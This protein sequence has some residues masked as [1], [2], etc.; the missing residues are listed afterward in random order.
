M[1][2][3]KGYCTNCNSHDE[4]R[5][6]F[7]VNSEAKFCYC[8]H[9]GKKYRPRIA[10]FN[11][12]RT[13][14]KYLRK[15]YFF[16]KNV[17]ETLLAYN[18]FA[19]V[20]ELEPTNRTAKYGRLLS[21]AYLS[22]LRRNRFKETKE[23]L[24]IEKDDFHIK[25]TKDEYAAFLLSLN[26]CIDDYVARV[27]RK[28][29]FRHYFYDPDCSKLYF[30]HVV[31]AIDLKRLIAEELSVIELE[32][33]SSIV[34]DSIKELEA[35]FQESFFTV[36]G[37]EHRLMNFAKS[38]DPL[39]VNGKKKEDTTRILRY[40]MGTLD[41]EEKKKKYLKDPVF[42]L[43]NLR[44]YKFFKISF[45]FFLLLGIAAISLLVVYFIFM[46]K[47]FAMFLL[48]LAIAFGVLAI[49]FFSLRLLFSARLKKPRL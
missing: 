3:K 8:P 23:L 22:N 17:G 27:K 49:I 38:G 15:A 25:S 12:E 37:Q 20:L 11:Y 2:M 18:L 6:I 47:N 31:D 34:T 26:H 32:K 30:K 36:D 42:A 19:Y 10:I 16:L 33:Q 35:V 5:R 24:S 21:L 43:A 28:I 48:V 45:V 4:S 13:I 39:I 41:P 29:T 9:C 40:R 44:M 46:K 7:D 14:N 1:A